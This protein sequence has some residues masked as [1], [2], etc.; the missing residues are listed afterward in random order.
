MYTNSQVAS[1][2]FSRVSQQCSPLQ[3]QREDLQISQLIF[4]HV[5]ASSRVKTLSIYQQ[6]CQKNGN[7]VNDIM[8]HHY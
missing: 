6:I 4:T 1:G 7:G 5:P 2:I 8:Y 3:M